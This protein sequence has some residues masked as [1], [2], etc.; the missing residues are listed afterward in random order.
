MRWVLCYAGNGTDSRHTAEIFPTDWSL[1]LSERWSNDS[2]SS[3][4]AIPRLLHQSPQ[5]LLFESF[6]LLSLFLQLTPTCLHIVQLFTLIIVKSSFTSFSHL[7]FGLP[8]NP[9]HTGFH[10]RNYSTICHSLYVAK[11]AQPLALIV[12]NYILISNSIIKFIICFNAPFTV[13][14]LCRSEYS[15]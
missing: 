2:E 6:G 9:V 3:Q 12:I 13:S 15:S 14:I 5:L 11:P 4:F 7:M 1:K 8:A 10:S